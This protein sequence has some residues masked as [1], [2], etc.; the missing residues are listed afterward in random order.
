MKN[1]TK[2]KN[3]ISLA[4]YLAS[5]PDSKRLKKRFA[6]A[7]KC[8]E[9]AGEKLPH[10]SEDFRYAKEDCLCLLQAAEHFI[11]ESQQFFEGW[12]RLMPESATQK[13]GV[14]KEEGDELQS[15]EQAEELETHLRK[16]TKDMGCVL[17][18]AESAVE[19]LRRA[20][21]C[22]LDIIAMAKEDQYLIQLDEAKAFIAE[23]AKGGIN[24]QKA[25]KNKALFTPA[26]QF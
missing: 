19:D 25:K 12:Q 24:P 4:M 26:L 9:N 22:L 6:R 3:S 8:Y 18:Q 5:N 7:M 23:K 11:Q 21:E 2:K 20:E 16:V 14:D 17:H 10:A 1:S 15:H 13:H